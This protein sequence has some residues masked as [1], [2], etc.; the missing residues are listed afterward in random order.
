MNILEQSKGRF[1]SVQ[2]AI[3]PLSL[4]PFVYTQADSTVQSPTFESCTD[5]HSKCTKYRSPQIV[6]HGTVNCHERHGNR[7][8]AVRYRLFIMA[9]RTTM[10]DLGVV[11]MVYNEQRNIPV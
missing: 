10:A 11:H 2:V 1:P 9:R 8:H 3:G 6:R 4:V 7:T 5:T